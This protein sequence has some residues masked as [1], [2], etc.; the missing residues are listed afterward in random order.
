M[1]ACDKKAET[2]EEIFGA[3]LSLKPELKPEHVLIDFEQAAIKALRK[4]FPD[5]IIHGCNFHFAQRKYGEDPDFALKIRWLLALAFVPAKY[6]ETA[7]AA[8]AESEFYAEN[9]ASEHNVPI[10]T[11]LNYVEATYVGRYDRSGKRKPAL[12][13][14]EMWNAY[15]LTLEG[16]I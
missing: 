7:F 9:E 12:F 6:V 13:P 16:K 15:E 5:A 4:M 14:I 10:Q 3:L 11:L 1:L 8:I 2:Y